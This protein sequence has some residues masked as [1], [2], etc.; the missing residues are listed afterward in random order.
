GSARQPQYAMVF[1]GEHQEIFRKAG[2]AR[3]DVQR[4]VFENTR[5]PV[6]E[7]KRINMLPGA[8]TAEDERTTYPLVERAQDLLVIA[9]GGK[10]GVQ[11][12][13]IPGWGSKAGSQSVTREIRVP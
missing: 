6:A 13:F 3:E 9:A 8:V 7:L 11:S 10:A 2:W 1:A 12:A 5:V 4:Y